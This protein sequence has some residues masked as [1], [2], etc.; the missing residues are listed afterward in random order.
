[1]VF[2]DNQLITLSSRDAVKNNGTYLSDVVF[3]FKGILKDENNIVRCFI[4][5]L[6]AQIPVSFYTI[7]S[8]NN[9]FAYKITSL[10]TL[11]TIILP[12]GNYTSTT[13]ISKLTSLFT[14]NADSITTTFDLVTGKLT[15]AS[16]VSYT[17]YNYGS[18]GCTMGNVLGIGTS[19]ISGISVACPY[20]LNLLNK[21]KLFIQSNSLFNVAYTSYNLGFTTTIAAIPVN[22]PPYNLLNYI[23]L[24]E[25]DKVII[26]N[27]TLNSIDIQILDESDNFINFNNID[28][29]LTLCLSIERE[30]QKK[31]H[32]E[33]FNE[34][35]QFSTVSG[36]D[37]DEVVPKK[38]EL[39]QD[40]KDL[41]LLQK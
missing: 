1:M 2:S 19:S 15:F 11:K 28:W 29:S 20:P 37:M 4:R 3:N 10:T 26:Y 35:L 34:F 27:T 9:V 40:E 14:A 25:S 18:N 21:K 5:V 30:D 32:I 39:T 38:K 16:G 6:N 41:E 33:N 36:T 7:D 13:L 24:S 17:Y 22:Q 23:S 31:S 12:V 8:S